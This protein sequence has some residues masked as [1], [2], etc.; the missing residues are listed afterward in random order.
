MADRVVLLSIPQLRHRD[1]TPGALASLEA[2]AG[3]GSMAEL[4]P[5][6]PGLAA[7][8]F[9]TLVTGTGPY[10]HGLIGNTYFDRAERRIVASPLPDSAVQAPRLWDRLR[11]A[12]P[13]ART[14]LWFAPN[15]RGAAVDLDA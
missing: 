4:V 12:H 13:E 6:F 11:E 2:L 3:R 14:M 1:V 10:E 7:S 5:P 15:S 8:S 9:A